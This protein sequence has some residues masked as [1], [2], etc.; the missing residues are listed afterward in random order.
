VEYKLEPLSTDD[1]TAVIDIFN[2]YVKNSYAAYWEQ[3][4][5]YDVF[6]RFLAMTEGF[7]AL[8]VKTAGG[9]TVGF[10]FLHAYHPADSM[11]HT[12]EITYF[13]HPD[14]TGK[15]LGGRVLNHLS[16]EAGKIGVEILLATVSSRNEGSLRFHKKHGFVQCGQFK[17]IGRKHGKSFDVIWFWKSLV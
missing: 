5:G 7:P 10:A 1:R 2:Y 16:D 11:R 6:D 17:D 4:V 3:T 12:A 9:E 14:H 15:G 8:A 13:I